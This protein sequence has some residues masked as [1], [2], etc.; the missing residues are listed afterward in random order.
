M[1]M[2][3]GVRWMDRGHKMRVVSSKIAIFASCGCYIFRNFIH[4][5]ETKIIMFE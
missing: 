2:F 1:P 5:N 3:V 4:E